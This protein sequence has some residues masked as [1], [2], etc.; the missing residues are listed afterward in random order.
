MNRIR[1]LFAASA[2]AVL[3]LAGVANAAPWASGGPLGPQID[4][5]M[6]ALKSKN[7]VVENIA[8]LPAGDPVGED[9]STGGAHARDIKALQAAIE[10]NKTLTRELKADGV[11]IRNVVAAE[12]AGDGSYIFYIS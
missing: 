10:H 3:G 9:Y 2:V 12:R 4:H 11:E 8:D 6:K 7:F 1:T 5:A